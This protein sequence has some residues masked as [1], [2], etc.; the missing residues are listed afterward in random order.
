MLSQ[1]QIPEFLRRHIKW[2]R[3]HLRKYSPRRALIPEWIA[4]GEAL[5]EVR[6]EAKGKAEAARNLLAE[7]ST[8]EFVQRITGLDMQVIQDLAQNMEQ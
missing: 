4:R 7:G 5:G 8:L 6:G 1:G 3:Q 2:I